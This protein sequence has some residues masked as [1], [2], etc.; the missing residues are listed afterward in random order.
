[1]PQTEERGHSL[2]SFGLPELPHIDISPKAQ[3]LYHGKTW[4][5]KFPSSMLSPSLLLSA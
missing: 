4:E 1:M 2:M 5:W 3:D